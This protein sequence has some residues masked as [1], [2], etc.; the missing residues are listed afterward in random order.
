MDLNRVTL[1]GNLA[2]DPELAKPRAGE[3]VARFALATNYRWQGSDKSTRERIEFHDVAA[4]GKLAEIIGVYVKRGS[5]IYVEG[6]LRTRTTEGK[7]GTRRKCTE[8]VADNLIMLG[9]RGR[10]EVPLAPPE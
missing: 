7:D 2:G 9:H 6:R 8:V 4:F 10:R 3:S 5:K 1:I